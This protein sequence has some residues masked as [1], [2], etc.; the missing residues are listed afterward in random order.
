MTLT[1]DLLDGVEPNDPAALVAEGTRLIAFA[2]GGLT[3]EVVVRD[4]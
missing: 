3:G 4:P 1:I 2:T